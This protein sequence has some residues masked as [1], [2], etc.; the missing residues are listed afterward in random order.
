MVA[1]LREYA[2]DRVDHLSMAPNRS[3]PLRDRNSNRVGRS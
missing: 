2:T 3:S 1:A